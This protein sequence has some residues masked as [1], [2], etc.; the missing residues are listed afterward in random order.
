MTF[1][2]MFTRSIDCDTRKQFRSIV[3]VYFIYWSIHA[4]FECKSMNTWTSRMPQ[5]AQVKSTS[6]IHF[7]NS[8]IK[9][10]CSA[11][12][13]VVHFKCACFEIVTLFNETFSVDHKS[14]LYIESKLI[15]KYS[16][17]KMEEIFV[18]AKYFHSGLK[19]KN[20]ETN[21]F[22][23]RKVSYIQKIKSHFKCSSELVNQIKFQ[24][25]IKSFCLSIRG[26]R[27]SDKFRRQ[28]ISSIANAN[29]TRIKRNCQLN[30]FNWF[31]IASFAHI[32]V[33]LVHSPNS[34][35][36]GNAMM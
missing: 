13:R 5:W 14:T 32:N 16:H 9:V 20:L 15:S 28:H 7:R 6:T 3:W 21:S 25:A 10:I 8:V 17:F 36:V 12:L 35:A 27:F 23:I 24:S 34:A 1:H 4:C 19:R 18:R 29:K 2:R 30:S 11:A 22:D 26:E 31:L 33:I